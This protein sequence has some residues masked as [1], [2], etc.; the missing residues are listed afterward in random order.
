M[1][2]EYDNTDRG[3]AFGP[4]PTQSLILQGKVNNR[5]EDLKLVLVKDQTRNG[6]KVIE[7]YQKVGVLFEN[8][9]KGNE[10]A[11][12]Y[13]GPFFE[14][15]RLAAWRKMK[16]DK[17]YMTFNV[18]DQRTSDGQERA[19]DAVDTLINDKVPF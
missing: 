6:M 16:D 12:D 13:T 15:R 7:V 18:S 5:G 11:P 1:A 8:D 3:A 17:A 14:T 2:E 10:S 9:K 19:A 4:F